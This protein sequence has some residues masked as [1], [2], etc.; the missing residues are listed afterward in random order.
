MLFSC[1]DESLMLGLLKM[2]RA[3]MEYG[4]PACGIFNIFFL[5]IW[6]NITQSWFDGIFVVPF[7]SVLLSLTTCQHSTQWMSWHAVFLHTDSMSYPLMV[8]GGGYFM[9]MTIPTVQVCI[10]FCIL[11]CV[12]IFKN[13]QS[14]NTYKINIYVTQ[15]I[16]VDRIKNLQHT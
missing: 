14:V 16:Q 13:A 9:T 12:R 4:L 15:Y 8:F 10:R 3:L 2:C 5:L 7:W 6:S 1:S 11:A